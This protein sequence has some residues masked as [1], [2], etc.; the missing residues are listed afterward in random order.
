MKQPTL[1][2]AIIF[3]IFVLTMISPLSG[4]VT[5][6]ST[7]QPVSGALLDLKESG[8][9]QKGLGMPK[10]KLTKINKL[11]P[12]F[13][14]TNSNSEDPA[15][16]ADETDIN[17]AHTGLLVYNTG[18]NYVEKLF[19]GLYVW[20]GAKWEILSEPMNAIHYP[21]CF[22]IKPNTTGYGI[23]VTKAYSIWREYSSRFG[24]T[25]LD[26]WTNFE[27]KILWQE[28]NLIS[29][30]TAYK[31]PL[32]GTGE[33]AVIRINTTSNQGNALIAFVVDNVI[34][35]SWHIWVTDYDPDNG[36][37]VYPYNNGYRDY[38]WMDRNLGAKSATPGDDKSI[39]LYYTW[40]RKDPFAFRT[41]F[42]NN[43]FPTNLEGTNIP[44][45]RTNHG[46]NISGSPF[47]VTY[48]NSITNPHV[49]MGAA[50]KNPSGLQW[51]DFDD[52]QPFDYSFYNDIWGQQSNRKSPF[53]PC[54]EGWSVPRITEELFDQYGNTEPDNWPFHYSGASNP[55][56]GTASEY[57]F[58]WN[59]GHVFGGKTDFQLGYFPAAG[60]IDPYSTGIEYVTNLLGSFNL[61]HFAF[62]G[63]ENTLEA[64]GATE[65]S[66][67]MFFYWGGGIT[68]GSGLNV[69]CV[70]E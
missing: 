62:R 45:Y 44:D 3:T 69:R 67:G 12:M 14:N 66:S 35:W 55:Y 28:G 47:D 34:R 54:P 33:H 20:D 36:G 10:V 56:G 23:P 6:G 59:Y 2:H 57:G 68:T 8:T 48:A 30:H 42:T 50:P 7:D 31:V 21:N 15:Y 19:P 37:T 49:F 64:G 22:I 11:Y 61:I 52:S 70:K 43:N 5:I 39:G 1:I 46:L 51:Y 18:I 25:N 17:I 40:G 65:G 4:Q 24:S 53:D 27:V 13:W 63:K 41:S 32:E 16:T 58:T 29:N 9:T 26:S 60:D 38:V